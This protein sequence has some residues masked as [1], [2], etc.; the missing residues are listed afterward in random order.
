MRGKVW[1]LET[2]LQERAGG[3]SVG[4]KKGTIIEQRGGMEAF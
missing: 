3:S 4:G 2:C 1:A